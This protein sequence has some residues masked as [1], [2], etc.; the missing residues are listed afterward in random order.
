M[1]S[2]KVTVR[3]G[4]ITLE[5]LELNLAEVRN[6]AARFQARTDRAGEATF[7]NLDAA[8]QYC[9]HLRRS[10]TVDLNGVATKLRL[11]GSED[12]IASPEDP[13]PLPLTANYE[14]A[15]C[16]IAGNVEREIAEPGKQNKYGPLA[17]V[18]VDLWDY[19]NPATPVLLEHVVT[20]AQGKFCFFNGPAVPQRVTLQFPHEVTDESDILTLDDHKIDFYVYPDRPNPLSRKIQYKLAGAIVTGQLSRG[21]KGLVGVDV[22]LFYPDTGKTETE[23]TDHLGYYSFPNVAAGPIQIRFPNPATDTKGVTWELRPGQPSVQ[24]IVIQADKPLQIAPVYYQRE[25]HAILWTVTA[26]DGQRAADKLV[27]VQDPNNQNQVVAVGRTGADG[28]VYLKL[29]Y[30]GNFM[31]VV[32]PY[33]GVPGKQLTQPVSV[34]SLETGS[35][36][37]PPEPGS[38]ART[39]GGSGG[40]AR[41]GQQ[42]TES[43]TDLQSFPVLTEEVPSGGPGRQTAIGPAGSAPIGQVAQNAIRD[44]LSWRTKTNDPK[45]FIAALNQSFALTDVEGHTVFAWTPRSY[46][47]QTDL[48]A[49]TGAQASIYTRAKVALDQSLPLLDGLYPLIP[50]VEPGDLES[51]RAVVRSLFTELVNE[52]GVEGGP[53]VPRV[54]QLFQLLRGAPTATNAEALP[55]H[56]QLQRLQ[57]RF[58]LER[59]FVNTIDDEQNLTNYLI[60]VDYVVGLNTSWTDQKGYFIRNGGVLE[61]Y[62]GTQLVLISRAL[63]VVAQS[64]K[65]VNFTLDSVFL[66]DAERQTISLNF[67]G[68]SLLRPLPG[69]QTAYVFPSNTS[70]LFVAELMD[71]TE[72][73]TSDELPKLLQDAGKDA[74]VPVTSVVNELR[75]FVRA[76]IIPPQ[77]PTRLSP[78]YKTPRVQ[79]ALVELADSL[80]EAYTL[81]S[82]IQSPR[83]PVF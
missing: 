41:Q 30:P 13:N 17:N 38:T 2:I 58:G 3:F 20:D 66:N 12:V 32:Y 28:T 21:E 1:A 46:T 75:H 8:L 44:V 37:I 59:K 62:F 31:V 71:W 47:V 43:V 23:T 49:V 54:D 19:S 79:R 29:P 67:A 40:A 9:L 18:A 65:D 15:G 10:I 24:A 72:R 76:A 55:K 4:N 70:A 33:D 68:V 64:V 42:I 16:R 69:E 27:E 35:S 45:A 14:L 39:G 57:N 22:E 73:A 52:F 34:H 77:V 74:I 61:P 25:E 53:R 6:P 7:P 83:F 26:A 60:L 5:D 11:L 78:G 82:K 81:A 80:D 63:D 48:G 51:V 50:N 36:T 56:C